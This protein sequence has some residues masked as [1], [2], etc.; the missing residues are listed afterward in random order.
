MVE[1][2]GTRDTYADGEE[3]RDELLRLVYGMWDHVKNHCPKVHDEVTNDELAWVGY[4]M[5][6]RENR[7]LIGDYVMNERD[8]SGQTLFPDRVAFAAWGIDFHHPEGFFHDG[9]PSD[10][11][12]KAVPHSIPYRSLY[13]KNVENLLMAGRDISASH[14]A[15]GATRNMLTS[16]A[17]GQVSGTAAA[18][19]VA[20]RTTPRGIFRA[21]LDDL[22]QQLL[23]DDQRI[24]EL[25]NRD[26]RDLA[27][28]ARASASSVK[29]D[30][31]GERMEAA[32]VNDG[33]AFAHVGKASSWAPDPKCPGPQW[34][35]LGWDRPATFDVVHVTFLTAKH[36]APRF[37]VEAANGEAWRELGQVT[38]SRFRKYLVTFPRTT[39]ARL[40]VTLIGPPLD[41]VAL[42]EIR[43]YDEPQ[44][45]V[46]TIGRIMRNRELPDDPPGPPWDA[47]PAPVPTEDP[48]RLGNAAP[49][50]AG[51]P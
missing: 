3:I 40:R 4:V 17:C 10:H 38:T 12:Y 34:I 26:P 42:C 19:C 41:H 31:R 1:I 16:A 37:R 25:P 14:V 45:V 50:S 47:F 11:V 20:R 2:G 43:V 22:Q 36:T 7:R 29:A 6:K 23:K 13:S 28:R 44:P 27:R 30:A 51:M 15:M 24:I 39:A 48:P 21:C 32:A 18:M 33:Y 46:N 8:I 49:R 35:E 9:P 5:G